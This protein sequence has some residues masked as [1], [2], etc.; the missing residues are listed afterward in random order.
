MFQLMSSYNESVHDVEFMLAIKT[1]AQ[2]ITCRLESTRK[3]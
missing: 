1:Q 2:H 3:I